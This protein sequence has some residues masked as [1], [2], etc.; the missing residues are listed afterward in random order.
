MLRILTPSLF[1]VFLVSGFWFSGVLVISSS[2][3]QEETKS[4]S[5]EPTKKKSK[6]ASKKAQD[7]AS[8]EALKTLQKARKSLI[9][10]Q[11]I[12]A[13][14]LETVALGSRKFQAKGKYLQGTDLKLRLEFQVK[15]GGTEGSLLEVCDGQV[16]W[17]RQ[18]IGGQTQVTRRDVRQILEVAAENRTMPKIMLQAELG[19]RQFQ[20]GAAAE[21][22]A[23]LP[24]FIPDRI[25]IFLSEGTL[26]PRRILY[27]K[28]RVK[29]NTFRPMVSLDFTN[30]KLN[31]PLNP[32]EFNFVPPDG[33]FQQ[34]ITNLYLERLAPKKPVQKPSQLGSPTEIP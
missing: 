17:S 21:K 26:F 25:R 9:E 29:Q 12:Q 4:K 1:L 23:P 33:V 10:Q 28:H 24:E 13:D 2:S 16:L 14:I 11:S 32:D 7:V 20:G 34:D 3:A 27:L 31:G 30:V 18:T 19:R 15:L 8:E 6:P 5:T 22:D